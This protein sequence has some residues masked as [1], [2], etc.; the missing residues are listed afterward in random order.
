MSLY[1]AGYETIARHN[2]YNLSRGGGGII[3]MDTGR[4]RQPA[5]PFLYNLPS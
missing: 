1:Y 5:R 3:E 4:R 2:L